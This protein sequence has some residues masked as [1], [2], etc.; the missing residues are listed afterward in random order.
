MMFSRSRGLPAGTYLD[1]NWSVVTA[2]VLSD[3]HK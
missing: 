1:H 3:A 2:P